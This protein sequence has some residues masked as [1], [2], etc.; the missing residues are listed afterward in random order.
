MLF[1]PCRSKSVQILN[2][3]V[4][5]LPFRNFYILFQ[6][7]SSKA[8]NADFL[9]E[10]CSAVTEISCWAVG[11]T[12]KNGIVDQTV[13]WFS[14]GEILYLACS[15]KALLYG[16]RLLNFVFQFS[17]GTAW[18]YLST[19]LG[20][21]LHIIVMLTNWTPKWLDS[22]NAN[23]CICPDIHLSATKTLGPSQVP[24]LKV[25]FLSVSSALLWSCLALFF[26]FQSFSIAESLHFCQIINQIAANGNSHLIFF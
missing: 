3:L 17:H 25:S 1:S 21:C 14:G 8:Q 2:L 5:C 26:Q 4:A 15:F 24:S 6:P 11:S 9:L 20:T 12:R 10:K 18:Q 19:S 7:G 23:F 16:F 22:S 13:E